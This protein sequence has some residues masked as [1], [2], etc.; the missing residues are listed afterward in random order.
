ML[1]HEL[2]FR[3]TNRRKVGDLDPAHPDFVRRGTHTGRNAGRHILGHSGGRAE[4]SGREGQE[5]EVHQG[6]ALSG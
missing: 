1:T 4:T 2:S 6:K 5:W 3:F